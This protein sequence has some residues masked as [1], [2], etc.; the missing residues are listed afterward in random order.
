MEPINDRPVIIDSESPLLSL[1]TNMF[2]YNLK[3]IGQPTLKSIDENNSDV[4]FDFGYQVINSSLDHQAFGFENQHFNLT[5]IVLT[6]KMNRLEDVSNA[7]DLEKAENKAGHSIVLRGA[8]QSYSQYIALEIPIHNLEDVSGTFNTSDTNKPGPQAIKKL[9]KE[10][11]DNDFSINTTIKTQLRDLNP[12]DFMPDSQYYSY[13]YKTTN[14]ELY[15]CVFIDPKFSHIVLSN[16]DYNI[17]ESILPTKNSS[18]T[19]YTAQ[20][21]IE[22][23][24][25]SNSIPMR[26]VDD[27]K[28]SNNLSPEIYIDCSPSNDANAGN[29]IQYMKKPFASDSMKETVDK[30]ITVILNIIIVFIVVYFLYYKL[31]G[32]FESPP[33]VEVVTDATN[34]MPTK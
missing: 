20:S 26:K 1:T 32:W 28:N 16:D 2:T 9:V 17:L 10:I 3:E 21:S 8:N 31:P 34:M 13:S 27:V 24:V 33:S 23:N 15:K 12:N 11:N 7:S 14:T 6:S 5:D 22:S 25:T 30:F 4:Y 19:V 29:L 18:N